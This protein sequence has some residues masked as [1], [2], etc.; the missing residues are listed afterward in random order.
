[1]KQ[2]GYCYSF[3]LEFTSLIIV[4]FQDTLLKLSG[5][6]QSQLASVE[7]KEATALLSS[8]SIITRQVI[9]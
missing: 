3:F 5:N 6:L 4:W 7:L 2:V 9:I 8:L 1:M